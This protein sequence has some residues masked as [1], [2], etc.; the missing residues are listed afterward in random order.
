MGECGCIGIRY[1][2]FVRL[3]DSRYLLIG[4]YPSCQYCHSPAGVIL[5]SVDESERD[6]FYQ[7]AEEI[8][9]DDFM[10]CIPVVDP[11]EIRK[12]MFATIN[13]A[14][15]DEGETIDEHFADVLADE[16]FPD[17]RHCVAETQ[18]IVK[19]RNT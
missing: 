7:D 16:A 3:P 17:L 18:R 19:E 12:Q 14:K 13:G 9:V 4:V 1:Q 10:A 15:P 8:L 5:Q 6:D 2:W 11:N